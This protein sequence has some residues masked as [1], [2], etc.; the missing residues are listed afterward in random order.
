MRKFLQRVVKQSALVF[1]LSALAFSI[2]GSVHADRIAAAQSSNEVVVVALNVPIDSGSSSLMARAVSVAQSDKAAAI[3]I[4]M[5]TPGGLL[6]D[7]LLMVGSINSSLQNGIPVYTFVGNDSIAASAGSYIAM[8]TDKI[9]M[10]PGSQIGPSTPIVVGGT[11]L[12]QNHTQGAMLT[13][14]TSLAAAHGRNTTAAYE[15]V[16]NDIAYSYSQALQYHVADNSSLS[17]AQTLS[18]VGLSGATIVNVGESPPEQ[19][20]S[21][22][23]NGTVDG[24]LLLVGIIA[25]VLDFIHPTV[26]LSIAGIILIAL[27]LIGADAIQS[28]ANSSAI[29]VPIVLFAAAAA[30]IVFELKT[31][32]GFMLFAGVAV[33]AFA[34][35]L[36]AYQVPYS[37]S[38]FTDTT[39]VELGILIAVGAVLALYA[40][41]AAVAL[42]KRPVTGVESMIGKSGII[43]SDLTPQGEISLDGIIWKARVAQGSVK[44][45]DRVVVKRVE[46]LVVLVEPESIKE[47]SES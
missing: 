4:N 35:I 7:M 9:F 11:S 42:R 32:H 3:I 2:A 43:V 13:L 27:G 17:L 38:P 30:L 6:D 45:G 21:F 5:N 36:L 16:Q 14:L 19:L 40:R 22:L 28:G 39:Y 24:I 25:I 44:K 26:V 33:G 41:W 31:G 1:L 46:G 34:T 15:M 37:P 10:A 12:E 20:V 8:A 18:E 47:N 29:A 23:S